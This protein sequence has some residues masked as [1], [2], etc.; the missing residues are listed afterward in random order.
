M[1]KR[2]GLFV[3]KWVFHQQVIDSAIELTNSGYYVD[4]F[5][6]GNT[7][8]NIDDPI[9]NPYIN[10]M[11]FTFDKDFVLPLNKSNHLFNKEYTSQFKDRKLIIFGTGNLAKKA[12]KKLN[13]QEVSYVVDNNSDKWGS[14]FINHKIYNPS[15]IHTENRSEVFILVASSYYSEIKQQLEDNGFKEGENFDNILNLLEAQ[16]F[17][18]YTTEKTIQ[19]INGKEYSYFVGFE[20]IGM[21]WA[22][23]ISKNY[24][25]P[26][27]YYSLELYTSDHPMWEPGRYRL[28]HNVEKHFHN[29]ACATIIQDKSRRDVLFKDNDIVEQETLYVTV[30]IREEVKKSENYF[31]RKYK[32]SPS[33]IKVLYWGMIAENRYCDEIIKVAQELDEGYQF[34]IHGIYYD[35]GYYN[36]LKTLDKKNKVV[37]S[38]ELLSVESKQVVIDSVDIG[39]C[40]Y[41]EA[42]LND[43]LTVYSSEKIA[44]FLQSGK[45]IITFDY[46][47]Y[48]IAIDEG[49]FGTYISSIKQMSTALDELVKNYEYYSINAR[50]IYQE[51][52]NFI[53]QFKKV[54]NFINRN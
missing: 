15:K 47:N 5:L 29:Q 33:K 40:F 21:I 23:I 39:L 20:K 44:R 24:N 1:K 41:K 27:M 51:K 45:P 9:K 37:F 22:G 54:I 17:E 4:I 26:Y 13:N 30:S 16:M 49:E 53:N 48:K 12:L 19:Y 3:A 34:I 38:T 35:E 6:Y 31:D 36:Y 7:S 46:D 2:I 14:Y 8:I 42:P 10:V 11:D 18:N 52:Y 32:I 43:K 50:K 25:I 28:L